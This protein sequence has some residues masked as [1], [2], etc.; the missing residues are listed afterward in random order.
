M[1]TIKIVFG[2]LLSLFTLLYLVQFLAVVAK[3][4]FSP[5][6]ITDIAATLVPVCLAAVF[7]IWLLKSAFAKRIP[8]EEKDE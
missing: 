4:G 5:A 2:V 7:A 6:G 3:G 8:E 1:K